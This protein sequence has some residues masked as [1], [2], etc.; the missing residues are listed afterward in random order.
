MKEASPVLLHVHLVVLSVNFIDLAMSTQKISFP[1]DPYH[2][3][4]LGDTRADAASLVC[5]KD[6]SG[7]V[8]A[9]EKV[10]RRLQGLATD[11]KGHKPHRDSVV[12]AI[13]LYQATEQVRSQIYTAEQ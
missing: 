7:L 5:V 4:R 1:V 8:T 13:H 2:H 9:F 12:G 6:V 11:L 10:A 3:S